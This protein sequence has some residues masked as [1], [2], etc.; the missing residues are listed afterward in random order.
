MI[1]NPTCKLD[2]IA[3][4]IKSNQC[5]INSRPTFA[6][7]HGIDNKKIYINQL[8]LDKFIEPE[9][10]QQIKNSPRSL[11]TFHKILLTAAN[12]YP[13]KSLCLALLEELN[14]TAGKL[15]CV[16]REKDNDSTRQRLINTFSPRNRQLM[17]KFKQLADKHLTVFAGDLTKPQLGLDKKTWHYLSQTIDHIFHA[18]ALVN[19]ILS[20]QQLFATN[21]I[22][23]GE[24]IKL[25]LINH[26]K[27]FVFISSAI[28]ALP[29]NNNDPLKEDI[30][31]REA[32]PYQSIND[33]YANGYTISKWAA[34]ILLQEAYSRFKLPVTIFRPNMILAHRQ[35]ATELNITDVF[36]RLSTIINTKVALKSFY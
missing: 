4:Y 23:T 30:N 33:Q 7:I 27:S 9:I 5:V 3:D 24:L 21:V 8:A 13:G 14:K 16:I 18:G 15:I 35:Y 17:F 31:I 34:E 36:T 25:A 20:Y 32:I 2:N 28:V 11:L 22:G 6:T 12:G 29:C 10:F 19:H 26:L 1:V